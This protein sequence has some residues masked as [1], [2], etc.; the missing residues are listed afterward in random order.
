M[1]Q[2][3]LLISSNIA[4]PSSYDKESISRW[5]QDNRWVLETRKKIERVYGLRK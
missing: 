4:V 1:R 5:L 2:P 3:A